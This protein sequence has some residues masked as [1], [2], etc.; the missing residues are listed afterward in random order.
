MDEGL[1]PG[2]WGEQDSPALC[3]HT[4]PAYQQRINPETRAD[5]PAEPGSETIGRAVQMGEPRVQ[6]PQIHQFV[7]VLQSYP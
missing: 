6:R 3:D 7:H 1:A 2:A 5:G 4:H